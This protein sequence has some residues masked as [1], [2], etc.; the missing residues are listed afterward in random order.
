[1]L[2]IK[3]KGY[4]ILKKDSVYNLIKLMTMRI[5]LLPHPDDQKK[6]SLIMISP[7]R[8]RRRRGMRI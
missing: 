6:A 1:M 4:F 8:S 5:T 7:N 3:I 2:M